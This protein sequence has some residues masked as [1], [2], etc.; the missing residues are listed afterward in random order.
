MHTWLV[1]LGVGQ[2]SLGA[3]PLWDLAPTIASWLDIRWAQPPDG[4]VIKFP[5]NGSH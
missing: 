4:H 5:G 2:G 1:L 3:V